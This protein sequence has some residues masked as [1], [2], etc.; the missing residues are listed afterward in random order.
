MGSHKLTILYGISH[1][2]EVAKMSVFLKIDVD[3]GLF[4]KQTNLPEQI[5][6]SSPIC[7]ACKLEPDLDFC[8]FSL[9]E[10]GPTQRFHFKHILPQAT[11]NYERFK[12]LNRVIRLL[13]HLHKRNQNITQIQTNTV[14][15]SH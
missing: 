14:L 13:R 4:P 7:I 5:E 2:L 9:F 11:H 3:S 10:A 1:Q 15:T 8:F 12:L 6:H